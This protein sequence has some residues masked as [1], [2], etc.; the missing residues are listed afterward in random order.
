MVK[1]Q[2]PVNRTVASKYAYACIERKR[3]IKAIVSEK[4]LAKESSDNIHKTRRDKH[5]LRRT[6][7]LY[8]ERNLL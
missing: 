8:V 7:Y 6:P 5:D 1:E 3:N 4:L 2:W